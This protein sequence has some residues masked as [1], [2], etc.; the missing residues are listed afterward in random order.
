MS[1]KATTLIRVKSKSLL[2][3]QFHGARTDAVVLRSEVEQLSNE[4]VAINNA[5]ELR[6][7]TSQGLLPA[8]LLNLPLRVRL[9]GFP[10]LGGH[11]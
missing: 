7:N 9:L 4:L 2:Y 11:E 10:R 8:V 1:L 3:V 6:L 5:E